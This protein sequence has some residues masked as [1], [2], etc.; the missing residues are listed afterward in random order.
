MARTLNAMLWAGAA[1]LSSA[2]VASAADIAALIG[3][4]EA[5]EAQL[6][7]LGE[8][9]RTR[10]YEIYAREGNTRE[11]IGAALGEV[12]ERLPETERLILVF[13]GDVVSA[14]SRAWLAPGDGLGEGRIAATLDGV[15]LD[16]LLAMASEVPGRAAVVIATEAG[17]ERQGRGFDRLT[18]GVG[19]PQVPQGVLLAVGPPESAAR[20]VS[21]ALLAE[22]G[23]AAALAD[24]PDGVRLFGFRAPDAAFVNPAPEAPPVDRPA[25]APEP[26]SPTAAEAAEAAE[27]GLALDQTARRRVQERLTVLG[28]NPRGIDGIFGP[29]TRAAIVQWQDA[30]DLEGTGFL[31]AEQLQLLTAL[32]DARSAELAA[33]A[34]Q[35]RRAEEAADA[36]FWRATG[37]NGGAADLRAYLERYPDGVYAGEAR[38]ALNARE[39]AALEAAAADDRAAWEAA[40]AED[41]QRAYQAYLDARPEGAFA[42]QARARI[43]ALREAPRRERANEAAAAGEEALGLAR[44]SRA[45]IEGQLAAIGYDAGTPDGTFDDATRRALREFQTR[46]GLEV[47][48]YV[49]QQTVQALIIA[50]L[51]LR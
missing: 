5:S 20:L 43:A 39:A 4:T 17:G 26:P 9:L 41:R 32:A 21:Q 22:T 45:L 16:L 18:P 24:A 35:A 31:S 15:P 33:A 51:G 6:E 12:A 46:Q 13:A 14:G 47:T 7:T 23:V 48:G 38:S 1:A 19:S 28:Y 44:G 42:D 25:A 27:A 40:R 3:A 36:E 50:S 2:P 34:E 49:D 37:A 11:A 8:L 29:G 10:G 30:Q